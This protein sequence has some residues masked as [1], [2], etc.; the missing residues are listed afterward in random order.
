MGIGDKA[1]VPG[2]QKENA[3]AY[4]LWIPFDVRLVRAG[5]PQEVRCGGQVPVGVLRPDVA[6]L[7][8][9]WNSKIGVRFLITDHLP[10]TPG[11][12]CSGRTRAAPGNERRT[13]QR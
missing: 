13:S 12:S 5:R 4:L 3:A 10:R 7:L 11:P 8:P 9:P 1:Q 2:Y 6:L